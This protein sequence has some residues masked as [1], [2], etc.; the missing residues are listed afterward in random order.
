MAAKLDECTLSEVLALGI[1]LMWNSSL[2][3]SS[4]IFKHSIGIT[5]ST[6]SLFVVAL[7]KNLSDCICMLCE[8]KSLNKTFPKYFLEPLSRLLLLYLYQLIIF[9]DGERVVQIVKRLSMPNC[10]VKNG[11][12]FFVNVAAFVCL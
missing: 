12:H 1:L 8:Q 3:K 5:I 7:K 11:L 9:E 2:K 6:K 10:W 4:R